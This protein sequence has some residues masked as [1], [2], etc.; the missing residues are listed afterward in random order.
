MARTRFIDAHDR[1][2]TRLTTR[3]APIKRMHTRTPSHAAGRDGEEGGA[4]LRGRERP[5]GE[6]RPRARRDV[7]TNSR[8]TS[9][10]HRYRSLEPTCT[11]RATRSPPVSSLR[12]RGAS[13]G[14]CQ[15]LSHPREGRPSDRP[16]DPH[17]GAR[18]GPARAGAASP[19]VVGRRRR[20]AALGAAGRRRRQANRS[21]SG[22]SYFPH[23]AT[24]AYDGSCPAG[25]RASFQRGCP[26]ALSSARTSPAS[27]SL[28]YGCGLGASRSG[29]NV[30]MSTKSRWTRSGRGPSTLDILFHVEWRWPR[31]LPH[32][33]TSVSNE[34]AS[35]GRAG[36]AGRSGLVSCT[37]SARN[38]P[39][40][41]WGGKARRGGPYL[42]ES[43][44]TRTTASGCERRRP[45]PAVPW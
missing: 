5:I 12:G 2:Q 23:K 35:N 11:A 34:N 33:P 40:G 32:S 36:A 21:S 44:R 10:I 3:K 13:R 15:R 16:G 26:F 29:S 18:Q 24:R 43:D 4:A 8:S 9:A 37:R 27:V 7:P 45:S 22:L 28:A 42:R 30:R 19:R 31:P 17:A 25:V 14:R 20:E 41:S 1:P 38:A 6:G 39:S